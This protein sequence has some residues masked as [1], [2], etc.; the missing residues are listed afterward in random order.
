MDKNDC[1]FLAIEE[2]WFSLY[3]LRV[4]CIRSQYESE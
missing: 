4:N 1:S 2:G 3:K